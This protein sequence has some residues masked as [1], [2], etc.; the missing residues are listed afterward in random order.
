MEAVG[1]IAEYNPFHNGHLYHLKK[2]K[3][4]FPD[5][6]IILVLSGNFTQRGIP[7]V[8]NKWEKAKIALTYGVDLI[9][10]L[11]Y[12]FAT[13]GA[14][15]FAEASITI[16]KE[17][18]ATKLVFGSEENQPEKLKRL[19]TIQLESPIYQEK[20][21]ELL[22]K[23]ENYPTAM[24][25]ALK[26]ISGTTV[27]RPN[28]L[29]GLSYT[30]QIL[31]QDANIETITIPRTNDYHEQ[32]SS[33]S[34][35]SATSIRLALK[36]GKDISHQVPKETQ[37][38]LEE[39]AVFIEDYF[40]FLRYR[41][42]TSKDLSQYLGVDEGLEH[43]LQR[44][45]QTAQNYQQFVNQVKTKRYTE[46]RIARMLLAILCGITKEEKKQLPT[47]SY[48]RILGFRT[49]GR[50]W[51]NQQKKKTT[52]PIYTTFNP[53]ELGFQIELR[54]TKVYSCILPPAKM[55]EWIKKE[56]QTG[57]IIKKDCEERQT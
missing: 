9:V 4:Q 52:L 3:E 30:K 39:Q 48:L 20:V 46:S 51:L 2:V 45:I 23:G 11:P 53:Q 17:L 42:M 35:A 36:E 34:I 31:K 14:D 43:R 29:L 47:V 49:K 24:S 54:T 40:P 28:D 50:L 19:A 32:E 13:Q 41:I 25:Q 10:E 56:Y 1:I 26:K 21:K 55:H 12:I 8:L 27:T 22:D 37:K 18:G 57:P 5:D 6:V 16:L 15:I 7:S 44:E 38:A 33:Q